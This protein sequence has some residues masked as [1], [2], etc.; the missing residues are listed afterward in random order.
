MLVILAI[1][2]LL[3]LLAAIVGSLRLG[4]WWGRRRLRL[5]G[6]QANDGLGT[7]DAAVFGM[8]GLLLA[9]TFTGAAGR[10]DDRRHLITAEVNAVGTAYL[11]MGL[12]PEPARGEVRELLRQYLDG[13]IAG[14][15]NPDRQQAREQ[16][17][18]VTSRLQAQIWARLMDAV[19]DSPSLPLAV[20]VLPSVN[21]SFDL[22]TTRAL[23]TRQ[24]PPKAIYCMLIMMVLVS[25]FLAGFGQ[26]KA[27]RQSLLHVAGFAVTTTLAL[28]LIIDLE[29]PRVGLVRVDDFDQALV[30]LR[31]NMK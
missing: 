17:N 4:W 16:V 15:R 24:H 9:F 22:A 5:L 2:L 20:A 14:Y 6:D 7:L 19:R 18:E 1:A 13:R 3:C 10:F 8:M 11:R 21:E 12:L 23:A 27:A 26:A 25:G 31:A 28:Y 30:E 29:Y